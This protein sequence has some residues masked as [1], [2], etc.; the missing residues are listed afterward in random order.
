[1]VL[2]YNLSS[3]TILE[4][5]YF[6][7]RPS[8]QY[9]RTAHGGD[10]EMITVKSAEEK[11]KEKAAMLE[12]SF[13]DRQKT[14]NAQCRADSRGSQQSQRAFHIWLLAFRRRRQEK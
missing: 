6:C 3:C 5:N 8:M 10:I 12:M 7:D 14:T 2:K 11:E 13:L 4:R 9:G 1:M